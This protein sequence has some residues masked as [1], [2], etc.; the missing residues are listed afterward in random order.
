MGMLK[1]G[2]VD[3]DTGLRFSEQRLRYRLHNSGLPRTGWPEKQQIP[4]WTP[5]RVQSRQEHLV[6]LSY[7]LDCL[8]LS[9]D[10]AAQRA[11]KFQRLRAAAR[12]VERCIKTGFHNPLLPRDC[13]RIQEHT[14]WI[15]MG[16]RLHRV[17]HA[18]LF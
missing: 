8:I 12:R 5:R 3:L 1:F 17:V 6:D 18:S 10:S 9:N 4:H 16:K 7:F 2:A 11:F 15:E 13:S 14:F